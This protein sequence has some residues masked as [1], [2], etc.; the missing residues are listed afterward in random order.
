MGA[1]SAIFL[2]FLNQYLKKNYFKKVLEIGSGS[3]IVINSISD[4]FHKCEAIDL[5]NRAVEFTFINSFWVMALKI[6]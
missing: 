6:Y 4:K 1:D 3:G 5:N 2:K